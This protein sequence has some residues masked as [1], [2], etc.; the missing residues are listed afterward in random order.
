M[1]L[2]R[3]ICSSASEVPLTTMSEQSLSSEPVPGPSATLARQLEASWPSIGPAIALAGAAYPVVLAFGMSLFIIAALFILPFTSGPVQAN[4]VVEPVVMVF[5]GGT[6]GAGIGLVWASI[7]CVGILPLVYL[8]V[9]SLQLRGSLIRL[10]AFAGGLVGFVAVLPFICGEYS[11]ARGSSWPELIFLLLVGPGLTT[12]LGQLGGAWG[13]WRERWYERAVAAAG[14]GECPRLEQV[15][16]S[17]NSVGPL[18]YPRIQFG[19]WHLLVIGMWLSVLLAGIRVSGLD[20]EVVLPLGM[21]WLVYQA[22]TLWIGG[23]LVSWVGRRKARR[24]GR[25]T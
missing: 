13:G 25:S 16:D 6:V 3:V 18:A 8:F 14:I 20:Y 2:K 17:L 1:M 23:R 11:P 15:A 9:L 22:A 12:I 19:I 5:L 7:V 21:G 10:G 24:Q 4:D